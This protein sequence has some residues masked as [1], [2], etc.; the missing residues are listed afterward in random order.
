MMKKKAFIASIAVSLILLSLVDLHGVEV[1][2]A[3]FVPYGTITIISP[4]NQ[5]YTSNYLFLNFTAT[6]SVSNTK[7]ITYCIDGQPNVTIAGL[8]YNGDVLWETTNGTLLL[9]YLSNGS[10]LLEMYAKTNSTTILPNT[11][12]DSV[13]FTINST[14]P[15]PTPTPTIT[16]IENM[17]ASISESASAVN[18]GSTINFTV[19][20]EGG[21]PPYAYTW[22][23]EQSSDVVLVE[24]TNSP[25]YSSNTFGPGS[26]HVYVEVKDADNNTAK[27]LAVEFNVLPSPSTSPPQT[28]DPAESPTQQPTIQPSFTEVIPF[29]D[30]PDPTKSYIFYSIIIAATSLAV[31]LTVYFRKVRK[32]K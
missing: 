30:P 10:H 2:E 4:T 3:N 8:Q 11:G 23:I 15:T 16:P 17:S 28:L 18:F 6:Y 12:Y 9:P 20:V 1:A 25:Y 32:Q 29:V 27:T 31:G 19:S 24:T 7:N 21:K 14:T 5:T 13:Y 26:H 22:N